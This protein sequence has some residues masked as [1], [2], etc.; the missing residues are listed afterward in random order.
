MVQAGDGKQERL[1]AA[2]LEG[3]EGQEREREEGLPRER[4][5]GERRTAV[6]EA[7]GEDRTAEL[8][9]LRHHRQRADEPD[10]L[11]AHPEVEGPSGERSA[12]TARAHDL[13][14]RPFGGAGCE[15]AAED[16]GTMAGR[17][18]ESARPYQPA[19]GALNVRTGGWRSAAFQRRRS[20]R[21][22]KGP[23]TTSPTETNV[24]VRLRV[25][26]SVART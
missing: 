12:A 25:N 7:G 16:G 13:G 11:R 23:P 4:D 17:H 14:D 10:E 20:I 19:E 1:P 22:F 24:P 21:T 26:W 6:S 2:R 15:R 18:G 3:Q 5:G 8:Q 9:H